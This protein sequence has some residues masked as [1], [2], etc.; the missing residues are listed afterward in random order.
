MVADKQTI[1]CP[2]HPDQIERFAAF[3]GYP[4]G[5]L[6]EA[7]R[8][9]LERVERHYAALFES[10][11]D[12]GG[13]RAP[14]SPAPRTTRDARDARRNGLCQALADRRPDPRLHHGHVRGP[15]C[16]GA[17][18][19]D[20]A[21]A[22]PA[23]GAGRSGRARRRLCPL[24]RVRDQLAGG[25]S[26]FPVS[27]Q[28]AP[29]RADRQTWMGTAPRLGHLDKL[30]P[31]CSRPCWRRTSSSRCLT[32]GARRRARAGARACRRC[33]GRARRRPPLGAGPSVPDRPAGAAWPAKRTGPVLTDLAEIVLRA[34]LRCRDLARG[35][36]RPRRRRP[37]RGPSR[38]AR[39]ARAHDRLRSRPDLHLRCRR[40]GLAR[41]L[42]PLPAATW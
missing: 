31:A 21:D 8:A 10:S 42:R 29:A 20:R 35:P 41:W 25:R 28:S 24:R 22:A 26:C 14:C 7:L 39:L 30:P 32:Q 38:Q 23:E 1:R 4:D 6:S 2:A 18:A 33:P 37:L 36:A 13:G 12:L 3:M 5:A 34:L 27:G 16:P 9:Q 15:G 17:R 40:D 11:I 19:S